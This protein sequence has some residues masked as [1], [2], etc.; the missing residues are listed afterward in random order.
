MGRTKRKDQAKGILRAETAAAMSDD[1]DGD[2]GKHLLHKLFEG[3]G[4]LYKATGH[5]VLIYYAP[6]STY[7][8]LVARCVP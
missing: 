5:G 2:K 4:E 8:P 7:P 1:E 3:G 6:S